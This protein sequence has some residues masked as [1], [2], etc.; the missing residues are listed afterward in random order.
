MSKGRKWQV[1]VCS[2]GKQRDNSV[3]LE[4]SIVEMVV[5]WGLY[6]FLSCTHCVHIV[7]HSVTQAFVAPCIVYTGDRIMKLFFSRVSS[8]PLDDIKT[9]V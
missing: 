9:V 8:T 1:F 5:W 3:T 2:W 4:F 7:Q 6:L